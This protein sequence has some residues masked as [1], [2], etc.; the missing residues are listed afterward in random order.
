MEIAK[1]RAVRLAVGAGRSG[2]RPQHRRRVRIHARTAGE[3]KT[4]FDPHVN[5]LRVT[6]E[7]LS[8]VLGGCDSLT[9]T[10][11]GFDAH[12][13]D[14]VQHILREESHLDKVLDPGAGSYYVEALT[15]ALAAEAW[16]LFQAIE[17]A[18][19]LAAWRDSGALDAALAAGSRA[20]KEKAVASRRRVLVGTNNYPNVAER[21]L[22]AA[23]DDAGRLA[24]GV[25]LRGDPPAHRAPRGGH[26]AGRPA[27]CC[28]SAAT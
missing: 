7:A 4:L 25:G 26:R 16:T 17:A 5:M 8:A 22:D 3:N 2:V 21:A 15:D 18:G 24:A 12:L 14:N 10:P 9:I 23:A 27:C 11:C 19:G 13:A 20:A 6:T 28:S 1:L